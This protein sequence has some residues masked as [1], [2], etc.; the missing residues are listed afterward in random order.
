MVRQQIESRGVRDPRV[1]DAMRAVEREQFLPPEDRG[2]AYDDRPL[3]IG[4]GQTI[5]QPYIV[6]RMTELLELPDDGEV[7]EIGA[8]C[9]YQTAVLAQIAG[10]VRAIERDAGLA[11]FA[12]ATLESLG[13]RRID[14]R[15]GD[16]VLGW[17]EPGAAFDGILVAC[18]APEVPPALLAQLRPGG[19]L[20]MPLGEPAEVQELIRVRKDADGTLE[21]RSDGPVRFV[22]M[23]GGT[24]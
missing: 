22:P 17:P 18:A 1:L 13:Y 8:G 19:H 14:L 24:A 15:H 10:R 20:V 23:V 7:L 4:G 9:G 6:A 12:R 16:G 11:A 2:L 3:P 21:I 5:S